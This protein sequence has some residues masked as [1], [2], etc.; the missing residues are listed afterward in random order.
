MKK[1]FKS[2]IV[3][4]DKFYNNW[5]FLQQ[6][7]HKKDGGFSKDPYTFYGDANFTPTFSRIIFLGDSYKRFSGMNDI[8]EQ[9]FNMTY[10][11]KNNEGFTSDK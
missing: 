11:L 9:H 6:I 3:Y 10:F 1:N 2:Q 7:L 5:F 4:V 8:I